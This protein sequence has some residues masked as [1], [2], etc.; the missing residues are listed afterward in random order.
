MSL[1]IVQTAAAC[2]PSSCKGRYRR[3]AILEVEDAYANGVRMISKH[4]KGVIR[5]V[6]TWEK[7]NVGQTERGAFQRALREADAQCAQLNDALLRV[8]EAHLAWAATQGQGQG[9]P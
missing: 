6:C 3:V 1:Y 7:L 4:A 2:M 8:C 9:A 5:V